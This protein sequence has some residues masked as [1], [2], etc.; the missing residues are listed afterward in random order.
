MKSLPVFIVH[1]SSFIVL[2]ALLC[3]E[4]ASAHDL[5][6]STGY[7]NSGTPRV[8]SGVSQRN[9]PFRAGGGYAVGA[10]ADIESQQ[11]NFMFGPSFLFWNNLTGDPD[12]NANASYMQIEFGGRFSARTRAYPCLYAGVGAG[13]TFAHGELKQKVFDPLPKQEYDGDFPTASVHAGFKTP[14]ANDNLGLVGEFSYHFGLDDP[15]GR[16]TV[17]PARAFLIQIGLAFGIRAG[18]QP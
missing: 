4:L 3:V 18:G 1:R 6:L 10:R 16:R 9:K 12:P 5:V 15:S 8:G 7:A 17:G 2:V 14:T 13:Y 11:R